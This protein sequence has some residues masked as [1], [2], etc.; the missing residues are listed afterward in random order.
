MIFRND[1]GLV[2]ARPL[3]ISARATALCYTFI[4]ERDTGFEFGGGF[5]EI[6]KLLSSFEDAI[7]KA[8]SAEDGEEF[9]SAIARAQKYMALSEKELVKIES[10]NGED[11]AQEYNERFCKNVSALETLLGCSL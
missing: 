10:D 4:I 11:F 5:V 1:C 8:F 7:I 3:F 2:L 9:F 6:N